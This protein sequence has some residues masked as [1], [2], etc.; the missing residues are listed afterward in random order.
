[1][2]VTQI[3]RPFKLVPAYNDAEFY[4]S[5]S[6]TAQ[7]NFTYYMVI[8]PDGESPL[9]FRI[10]PDAG[11]KFY[12]NAIGLIRSFVA[13]YYPFAINDWT[14]VTNGLIGFTVNIGE[15]YG[16]TPAI[17]SGSD[18]YFQVW[19]ASLTKRERSVYRIADYACTTTGFKWLNNF[20][21]LGSA[22][23]KYFQDLPFSFIQYNVLI[24]HVIIKTYN[25]GGLVNT[26]K[27]LNPINSYPT[28]ISINCSPESLNA[29]VAAEP[30]R[31]ASATSLPVFLGSGNETYYTL[32]FEDITNAI[33]AFIT[34]TIDGAC[35][36]FDNESL[37]YLSR[38]GA[39]DFFNF[40]GNHK[41]NFN[42]DK[43]FYR[44]LADSFEA[45]HE[46]VSGTVATSGPNPVGIND[47][48]LNITYNEDRVLVTQPL[49]QVEI[50]NLKDLYS[51]PYVFINTA[52]NDYT[53]YS[54]KDAAFE[55]KQE[56]V[57]KIITME[58]R[59]NSGYT[60]VRQHG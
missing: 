27:I 56:L 60:E 48:A 34:V 1:M 36:K 20:A 33:T 23:I 55:I 53:K 44:S 58:A 3:K 43:T 18:Y 49:T 52:F 31:V 28:F 50:T 14:S 2:A 6:Q 24:D 38:K 57:E 37:Y 29:L 25:S 8:T 4:A 21:P 41:D 17:H 5:S 7:P 11:G 59:L 32:S 40:E 9:V 45:S 26:V 10:A 15:E 39:F 47:K 46:V 30:T 54:Q 51:T 42:V 22:S 16:S 13:N 35:G 12:Y 19:N